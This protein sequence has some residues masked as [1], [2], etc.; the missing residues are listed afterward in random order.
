MTRLDR[1]GLCRK[2][3]IAVASNVNIRLCADTLARYSGVQTCGSIHACP[4]CTVTIREKRKSQVEAVGVAH[5]AAGGL[6]E[7]A[8]FTLPHNVGDSLGSTLS[9]A[10]DAWTHLQRGKT[11]RRLKKSGQIIGALVAVEITHGYNGW[12]P[13]LHVLL[14]LAADVDVQ[15]LRPVMARRW[16]DGVEESGFRRPSEQHGTVFERV[17][18]SADA[19][20][21]YLVK[22]Q[23]GDAAKSIAAELVRGHTKRGRSRHLTP[24]QL[25][26]VASLGGTTEKQKARAGRAAAL[27]HEYELATKG[28]R[29]LTGLAPLLRLYGVEDLDDDA[30]AAADAVPAPGDVVL[31]EFS[32]S[33]W[34]AV[35]RWKYRA[36][37]LK[38]AESGGAAAVHERLAVLGRREQF[39]IRRRQRERAG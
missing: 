27:W 38:D 29:A 36:L 32:D 5:L 11:Y 37:L 16:A 12:H 13:H 9:A 30:A 21:A 19:L 33:E 2:H 17:G 24:F 7:F 23:D 34:R 15:A 25:L 3:R 6:L 18:G 35:V 10:R 22:V 8:T 4:L 26:E 31:V 20:A 14:F 1:V 28:R 39:E